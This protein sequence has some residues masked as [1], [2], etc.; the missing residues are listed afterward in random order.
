MCAAIENSTS[1]CERG[2]RGDKISI[3]NIHRCLLTSGAVFLY[4]NALSHSVQR[5]QGLLH[6]FKRNVF[7]HPPYNPDLAPSDY[8]LFT[9]MKKW[10]RAQRFADDEE[11]QNAV[12]GWLNSRLSFMQ[13]G[14]VSW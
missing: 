6:Q 12:T 11:L 10:L 4:D 5:T 7:N 2:T 13:K 9:H 1:K 8:H 14:F 3:Q